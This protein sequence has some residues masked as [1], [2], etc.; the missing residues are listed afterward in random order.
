MKKTEIDIST[1]NMSKH[2][3]YQE[4]TKKR[5]NSLKNENYVEAIAYSYAMIEDRLLSFLH[6]LYVI[7]RYKFKLE[8][9]V[10]QHLAKKMRKNN[11]VESEY[12]PH[13]ENI[14]TKINIIKKLYNY[15]GI[16]SVLI[17]INNH[18]K[19]TLDVKQLQNDIGRLN[20]W[21]N[22]R[23]EITHDLFNKDLDD[24][25]NK[26]KSIAEEGIYLS[27]Q[28]DYYSDLLKGNINNKES[29]RKIFEKE[30]EGK[31]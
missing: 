19:D 20:K 1:D 21:L 15:K 29:L 27:G 18:I 2:H 7:D 30:L 26:L 28:Y 9:L 12:K 8:D 22:Y 6:H 10:S 13:I 31:R 16:D 5:D 11:D 3:T 24:L 4:L 25:N 17:K 23:N 14:S